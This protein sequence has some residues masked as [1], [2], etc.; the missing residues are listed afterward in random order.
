M[1][2]FGI[3]FGMI[4]WP[5]AIIA[6]VHFC[7]ARK[8]T[9]ARRII[10]T[11]LVVGLPLLAAVSMG[12]YLLLDEPLFFAVQAGDVHQVKSLLAKGADA[13]VDFKGASPLEQA[14]RSGNKEIVR[15]LLAH[16]A[17]P[18]VRNHW[19]G[20]T[21]LQSAQENGHADIVALLQKAK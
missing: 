8:V 14:A 15:L 16:G 10:G 18:D 3:L 17:R 12:K 21:A 6:W 9:K 4:F 11:S 5:T 1:E 2:T 13:N 19:N 7:R 20:H